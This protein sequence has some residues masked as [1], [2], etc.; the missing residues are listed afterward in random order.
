V[1]TTEASICNRDV[2]CES[3][4][5][6]LYKQQILLHWTIGLSTS[7]IN[8]APVLMA[9]HSFSS[10]TKKR[11]VEGALQPFLVPPLNLFLYKFA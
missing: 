11:M 10:A 5:V 3:V 9:A 6:L 4:T 8:A 2:C 7:G 1:L